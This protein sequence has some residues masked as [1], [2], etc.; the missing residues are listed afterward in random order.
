M[1]KSNSLLALDTDTVRL[2][3]DSMVLEQ[4]KGGFVPVH[5]QRLRYEDVA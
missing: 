2:F 5:E 1:T 3:E 4:R